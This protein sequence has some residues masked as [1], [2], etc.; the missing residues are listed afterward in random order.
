MNIVLKFVLALSR[1]RKSMLGDFRP[2]WRLLPGRRLET[3]YILP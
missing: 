3:L 1:T 2:F